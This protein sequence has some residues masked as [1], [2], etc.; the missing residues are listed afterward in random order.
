MGGVI[1]SSDPGVLKAIKRS[2]ISIHAYEDLIDFGNK[3]K[4]NR[5]YTWI[6]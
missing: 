5:T 3:Q 4:A 1:Q 6:T 2:N